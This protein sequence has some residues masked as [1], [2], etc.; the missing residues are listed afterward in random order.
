MKLMSN[1]FSVLQYELSQERYITQDAFT[2]SKLEAVSLFINYIF[3][4]PE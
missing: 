4:G 1:L 2:F 3:G